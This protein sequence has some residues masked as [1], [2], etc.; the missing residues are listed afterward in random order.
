MDVASCNFLCDKTSKEY[1]NTEMKICINY[2]LTNT[3]TPENKDVIRKKKLSSM[4]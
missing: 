1:E 2:I 3:G 4:S